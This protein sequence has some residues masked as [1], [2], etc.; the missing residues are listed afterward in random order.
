MERSSNEEVLKMKVD[1][2]GSSRN[3]FASAG[4]ITVTITLHEYR[5]LVSTQASYES[6]RS[7]L[8]NRESELKE[9]KEKMSEKERRIESLKNQLKLAGGLIKK[10]KST[11]ENVIEKGAEK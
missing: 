7:K 8:W 2:Y 10:Y 3:D 11:L 4:E 1:A 6:T 5:S 9:L